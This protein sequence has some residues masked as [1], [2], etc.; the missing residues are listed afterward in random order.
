MCNWSLTEIANTALKAAPKTIEQYKRQ[1]LSTSWLPQ[2][3]FQPNLQVWQTQSNNVQ[4]IDMTCEHQAEKAK[5]V[6]ETAVHRLIV[7]G[8]SDLPKDINK[9]VVI[10]RKDLTTKKLML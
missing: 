9:K 1:L 8:S 3:Q 2:C 7:T 10:E 5:V 6:S 4:L